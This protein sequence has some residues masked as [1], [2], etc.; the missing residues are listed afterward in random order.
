L[1][2]FTLVLFVLVSLEQDVE[3]ALIKT[4]RVSTS[5]TNK[6]IIGFVQKRPRKKFN[7]MV[8]KLLLFAG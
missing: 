3:Q 4:F 1:D 8:K 5:M 7:S 6:E 2:E